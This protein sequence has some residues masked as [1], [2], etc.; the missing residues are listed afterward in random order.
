[1]QKKGMLSM[2]KK[3]RIVV[4]VIL[5]PIIFFMIYD[6]YFL[7]VSIIVKRYDIF[8]ISM[9][10]LTFL[11]MIYLILFK[12]LKKIILGIKD[13]VKEREKKD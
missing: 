13:F 7:V 12:I 1:M 11:C 10:L 9:V 6:L 3:D 8:L 4:F 2:G 5:L